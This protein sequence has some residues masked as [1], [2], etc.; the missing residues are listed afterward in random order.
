[1][2][3]TRQIQVGICYL[4]DSV[5]TQNNHQSMKYKEARTI[6]ELA[7]EFPPRRTRKQK[8]SKIPYWGFQFIQNPL[9]APR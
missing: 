7:Q 5:Q 9:K 1:M 8:E 4:N 2:Q 3:F 6:P